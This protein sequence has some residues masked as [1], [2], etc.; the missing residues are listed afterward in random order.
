MYYKGHNENN[1]KEGGIEKVVW[2]KVTTF[3]DVERVGR[4]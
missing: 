1:V 2:Q 3:Q 4:R